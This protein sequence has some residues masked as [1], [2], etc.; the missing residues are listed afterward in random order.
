MR[1]RFFAGLSPYVLTGDSSVG[2]GSMPCAAGVSTAATIRSQP[3]KIGRFPYTGSVLSRNLAMSDTRG[4]AILRAARSA[5]KTCRSGGISLGKCTACS[6]AKAM[7]LRRSSAR[8]AVRISTQRRS[9]DNVM[10]IDCF[11][12]CTLTGQPGG[13]GKSA[14]SQ[15][16]RSQVGATPC[17]PCFHGSMLILS[18]SAGSVCPDSLSFCSKTG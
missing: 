10:N 9:I 7:A 12:C 16:A 5:S 6:I 15:S 18:G 14:S 1:G 13:A 2:S 4:S 17:P 8:P 11:S 3:E